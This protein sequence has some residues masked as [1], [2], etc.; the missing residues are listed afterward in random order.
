MTHYKSGFHYLNQ[1]LGCH[2]RLAVNCTGGIYSHIT[3]LLA[4][5]EITTKEK[6]SNKFK[7][8]YTDTILQNHAFVYKTCKELLNACKFIYLIRDAESTLSELLA[9]KSMNP[10]S[11]VNYYRFRLQ[12]LCQLSK[13]TP[14]ALFL[15]WDDLESQRAFPLIEEYLG[16]K[17]PLQGPVLGRTIYY[18]VPD[19]LL[20]PADKAYKKYSK[21]I[22]ERLF[23][24]NN[25]NL[26][27]GTSSTT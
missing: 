26:S 6:F 25:P 20:L 14:G 1:I 5:D 18:E 3:D 23:K 7:A 10:E 9:E 15:T 2:P 21:K 27:A 22:Q 8:I 24:L 11:A 16:L 4:L 12:R 19:E 17:M 13:L